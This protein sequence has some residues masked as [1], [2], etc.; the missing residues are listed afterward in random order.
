MADRRLTFL[1]RLGSS[2]TLWVVIS[3]VLAWKVPAF[4]LALICGLALVA[5][6]E[7]F[8]MLQSA[9]VQTFSVT[10]TLL[11]AVFLAGGFLYYQAYTIHTGFDLVAILLLVVA[12]LIRQVFAPIGQLASCQATVFTLFGILYIPWTFHFLSKIIFLT[13]PSAN[14]DPTGPFYALFVVI[15]TKCSDMGAYMFGG[16]FGRHRLAPQIS[17]KKTWE[18][19]LGAVASAGIVALVARTCFPSWIPLFYKTNVLL[20][21]CSLGGIAI[22]G[23][24]VESVIKRS[25]QAKDSGYLLPGI[26]GALDLIDSLLFTGPFLF[27][28]LHWTMHSL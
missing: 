26:G 16:F 11:S 15:V 24:L 10:A 7:F 28:Y 13:P 18:G 25:I 12:L 17:P 6:W 1:L 8:R 27:F 2:I 23:D 4:Y 22:I 20:L 14:G 5:Q 19:F 9:G 21:G 3:L